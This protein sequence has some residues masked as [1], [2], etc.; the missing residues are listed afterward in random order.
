MVRHHISM[1]VFIWNSRF[2]KMLSNLKTSVILSS[3]YARCI[4]SLNRLRGYA[5][6]VPTYIYVS[7]SDIEFYVQ[8]PLRLGFVTAAP[9]H[10]NTHGRVC[11]LRQYKLIQRRLIDG[12]P[13]VDCLEGTYRESYFSDEK[14]RNYVNKKWAVLDNLIENLSNG[15]AF[16][17]NLER[18][19]K[20]GIDELVVNIDEN[21]RFKK[22]IG[23]GGAHRL[24]IAKLMKIDAFP[25]LIGAVHP[26][27][28][29][30]PGN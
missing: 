20:Y 25:C 29:I 6:T 4:A 26:A 3:G 21:G 8:S 27:N 9:K 13:W 7:P 1:R 23:S 2:T 19:V 17:T 18:D 15:G 11:N 5:L 12:L 16:K 30:S 14:Y 24:S 10:Y 28:Y 22:V